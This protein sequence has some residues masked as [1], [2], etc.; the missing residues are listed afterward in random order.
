MTLNTSAASMC[1]VCVCPQRVLAASGGVSDNFYK[2]RVELYEV[3]TGAGHTVGL[4]S[5]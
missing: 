2:D 1:Y 4:R 5:V 3:D